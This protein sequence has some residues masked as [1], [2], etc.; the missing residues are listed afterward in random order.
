M[1]T[2][3]A[4]RGLAFGDLN[5]DDWVDAVMTVLGKPPVILINRGGTQHWLNIA[6]R[7]NRSNRDGMGAK[8]R[9]DDQVRFATTSGSYLSANDKR[10]HFGLGAKEKVCVEV[11][12]PSGVRQTLNDVRAGQFLVVTEPEH[13]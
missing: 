6:L 10:L 3:V 7:G 2:P 5:N 12:W 9:V 13:S 8:V 1:P 11:T 4:G